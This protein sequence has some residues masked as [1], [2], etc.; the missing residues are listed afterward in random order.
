MEPMD[1]SVMI[2]QVEDLPTL[3]REQVR[4]IDHS[5]RAA[6]TPLEILSLHR[7]Y[8]TGDGDS[9]HGAMASELAFEQFAGIACEPMSA[10]RFLEYGADFM[11]T[12]F[13]NDTL[14][15][16]ISASGNT[17]RVAD[18]LR[19]AM[20]VSDK[21][22]TVGLTGR[23]GSRVAEAASRRISVQIPSFGPSPGIRTYSATLLGLALL[24][25]RIGEIRGRY[26]NHAANAMREELACMGD[27]LAASVQSCLEPARRAAA[28]Y[29]D[30]THMVWVGS[31]PSYGTAL[32]SAAKIVEAAGVFAVGQD[33]E[34]WSHVERFAY[35]DDTPTFVVA[36]PGRSYQRALDLVKQAKELGRRVAAVV[37]A[38]DDQ[39]APLADFVFPVAPGIREEFSPL[40]YHLPANYFA[41]FLAEELGRKLFQT[42]HPRLQAQHS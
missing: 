18:C 23:E 8:I 33:L 10:M 6:L 17:Q 26:H 34:E 41:S 21:T 31:G 37:A 38:G 3:M 32:F 1:P 11:F 7:I 25:I 20:E 28:A 9:Y 4:P 12:S 2:R 14:V 5:V 39:I 24:A 16:G 42:D 15:V 13:P 27:G 30:A 22:I 29:K 36:P 40:A 19:R 35:P